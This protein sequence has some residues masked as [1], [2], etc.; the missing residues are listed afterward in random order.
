MPCQINPD[1]WVYFDSRTT[2]H[3]QQCP[4]KPRERKRKEEEEKALTH[5]HTY[6]HTS[7]NKIKLES[8]KKKNQ[9]KLGDE[10]EADRRNQRRTWELNP[11]DLRLLN[12]IDRFQIRT[13]IT[14]SHSLFLHKVCTYVHFSS[15][16]SLFFF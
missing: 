11:G 7:K 8:E 10:C 12:R 5:T 9:T 2:S 14:L 6:M 13:G 4:T 3:I 1:R 15:Y 16:I